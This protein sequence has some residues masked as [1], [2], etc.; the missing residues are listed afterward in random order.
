[1]AKSRPIL[2]S[3]LMVEAILAGRKSMTRRVL[4]AGFDWNGME[5]VKLGY[6]EDDVPDLLGT[7]A[8]FK[9]LTEPDKDWLFGCRFP[10]GRIGDELWVREAWRIVGWDFE[11]STCTIEYKDG[12]KQ[13]CELRDWE[14]K[15]FN[16]EWLQSQIVNMANKGI[17]AVVDPE[18]TTTDEVFYKW[19][20]KE[21]SWKPSIHMPREASRICLE[22]TGIRVERLC[23]ISEADAVAEGIEI[24]DFYNKD[25]YRDYSYVSKYSIHK[26]LTNAIDSFHSLWNSING[27]ESWRLNPWVWVIEFRKKEV[28]NGK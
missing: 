15:S 18:N 24:L 11:E 17:L 21:N 28:E 10:F 26:Y 19:T 8:F 1:M 2:F 23:D 5:F 14:D 20:G 16:E 7:Q 25:S 12:A 9:D 4:K 6:F 22:I 27:A 3:T 13:V